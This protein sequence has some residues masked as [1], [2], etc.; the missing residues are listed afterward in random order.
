VKN[1]AT[2]R[3][4]SEA[5]SA[6][7][8]ASL[9]SLLTELAATPDRALAD[10]WGRGL[11]PGEVIAERFEL[12]REVGRGGFGVVFE[13]IDRALKRRVAF[14]AIR[15]GGRAREASGEDVLRREADAIAQ[16]Q[17][18]SIVTLFDA[19]R[20]EGGP[21]LILELL[22]G[23]TLAERLVRG[24]LA[25]GDALRIGIDVG[26]ALAHAHAH[27]VLH[28]DLKP[29][30]VFLTA[31]G[32]VKVLD[33]GLAHVF[34]TA[35][36]GSG[37]PGYMAPEQRGGGVED[38]RTD[39]YALGVLL[40]E[41]LGGVPGGRLSP[42]ARGGP[43][44]PPPAALAELVTAALDPDPARR[45][46]SA[47]A[48]VEALSRIGGR[49]RAGARWWAAAALALLVLG[50]A[51]AAVSWRE[52]PID[53]EAIAALAKADECE[54]RPIH[55][56]DCEPL[57]RRAVALEP[58]LAMAHYGL[59]VWLRSYGG[60]RA[61]QEQEIAAALRHAHRASEKERL[62]IRAWD[63]HI[64]GRDDEALA[65]FGRVAARWPDERRA[66]FDPGEILRHQDDLARAI[67]YLERAA[68]L[69][70][71]GWGP[72]LLMETL[73]ATGRKDELRAW[74]ERWERAPTP[75]TLHGISVAQGWLGDPAAAADAASRAI[76]LGSGL[77]AQEDLLAAMFFTERYA[78]AA[79]GIRALAQ[80]GSD[81]Q[82]I[83]YYALAAAEAYQGRHAAGIAHLDAL[84]RQVPDVER[85][86]FYHAIRADYVAGGGSAEA[87]WRE[88]EPLRAIDPAAAAEHAVTLAYLGDLR[89][90]EELARG[91]RP[92]SVLAETYDAVAAWR[93]QDP[94]ALEALRRASTR[95]PVSVW[96][97]APLFLYGEA[98]AR[99]GDDVA[100]VA[101]LERV[102]TLYVPR[103]MWRSWAH[104]RSLVLLAGAH[105]RL[106]E[107]AKARAV[108]DRFFRAWK[109]ADPADPLL[110]EARAVRARL[111]GR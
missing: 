65:L 77:V 102:Q 64:A 32:A 62:L 35:P 8:G 91:L 14:K 11:A 21:Y 95:S 83:G 107:K 82:R 66:H 96:R 37:T 34:G 28:R 81:V 38:E 20:S 53:A 63:A 17:H 104:P 61:E 3:P 106:G 46:R 76:A 36:A 26:R 85:D 43:A 105:A 10:A 9:S 7:R 90:A 24:P 74:V 73:G 4:A 94:G 50:A 103:M 109:D 29:S 80:P 27:G 44:E 13:A 15:A 69:D 41:M 42:R 108:L 111:G 92:G 84:R 5:E 47:T 16:L 49:S 56:K 67:P 12:V 45:P 57:Y 87:V 59:A 78:A 31:D 55:G 58:R 23:E 72:G 30:N 51:V 89:R 22:R 101:A 86:A 70:P 33:F 110:A 18:P 99:S 19:G 71:E 75:W 2:A 39:V 1:T 93:R 100:A 40:H 97:M 6:A 25:I 60:R 68:E 79:V 98:A 88:V 52:R 48:V 54:K